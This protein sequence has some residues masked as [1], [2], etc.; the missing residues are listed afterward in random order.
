MRSWTNDILA[1]W[2]GDRKI[3]N[4]LSEIYAGR[5]WK[6]IR[7]FYRHN[8]YLLYIHAIH[9]SHSCAFPLLPP[10]FSASVLPGIL[11]YKSGSLIPGIIA[12]SIPD[13]FDS[14][15][16]WSNIT[17]GFH[18]QTIFKTVPDFH[19]A[20]WSLIFMLALLGFFRSIGRLKKIER[21]LTNPVN[22]LQLI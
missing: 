18:E 11:A 17:G 3:Y 5:P 22:T 9:L 20:V 1:R 14:S 4:R 15:F 19:F 2:W 6:K 7:A 8:H 12:H 16:W 10:I 13:V 21:S